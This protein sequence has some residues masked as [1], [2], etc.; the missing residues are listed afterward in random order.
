MKCLKHRSYG[1]FK[2]DVNEEG[3][4]IWSGFFW[5]GQEPLVNSLTMVY[6][7]GLKP[8]VSVPPGVREDI[9]WGR[10]KYL[11]SIKT[12]HRNHV[13]LEPV[14]ILALCKIRL[15]IDVLTCQKQAQ[16]SY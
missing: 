7:S 16:S 10:R 6:N 3:W 4:I 14:L 13:S 11:T 9:L 12:K 2:S 15:R 5:V 8:G 1:N